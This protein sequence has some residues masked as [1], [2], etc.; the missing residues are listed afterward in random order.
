MILRFPPPLSFVASHSLP[1]LSPCHDTRFTLPMP[2]AWP[3]PPPCRAAAI[4]ASMLI[5]RHAAAGC[6]DTLSPPLPCLL[7]PLIRRQRCHL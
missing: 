7:L 2:A 6:R 4:I 1:T 3:P 5:R